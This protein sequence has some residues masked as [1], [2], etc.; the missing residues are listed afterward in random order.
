MHDTVIIKEQYMMDIDNAEQVND[1]DAYF[2]AH[3]EAGFDN[4]NVDLDPR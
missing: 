2:Y 4:K 3:D 1:D